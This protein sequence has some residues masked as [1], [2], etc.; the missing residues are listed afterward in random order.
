MP[1]Q[2]ENAPGFESLA[3][4]LRGVVPFRE[5]SVTGG[6]APCRHPHQSPEV[7][8]VV[9][10]QQLVKNVLENNPDD[11]A[12]NLRI[13]QQ[14]GILTNP[15]ESSKKQHYSGNKSE[16]DG[17]KFDSDT[18]RKYYLWLKS[19]LQNGEIADLVTHPTY[20][21]QKGF[22]DQWGRVHRAIRYTPDF[23]YTEVDTG[24]RVVVD[25]KPKPKNKR[26]KRATQSE[27]FRIRVRLFQYQ[28][29]DKRFEVVT[30]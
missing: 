5:L 18:E 3:W 8:R 1:R 22:S 16:L 2:T 20:E 23:E 11:R 7:E 21:L 25:V 13:L 28:N 27:A 9:N 30:E 24:E 29:P 4:L 14:A 6:V 19:R 10:S 12:E 15:Q 26:A 17:H